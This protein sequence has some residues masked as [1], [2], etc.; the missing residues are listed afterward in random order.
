MFEYGLSA[1][2]VVF[3]TG[4]NNII[5]GAHVGH[6][7]ENTQGRRRAQKGAGGQQSGGVRSD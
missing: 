7:V 6:N 2:E 4:E 5:S 1:G 3:C